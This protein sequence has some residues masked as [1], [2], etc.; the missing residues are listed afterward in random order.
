MVSIYGFKISSPKVN[1]VNKEKKNKE[2]KVTEKWTEYT[3]TGVADGLGTLYIYG[4]QN[5][6]PREKKNNKKSKSQKKREAEQAK[7]QEELEANPFLSSEDLE[8]KGENDV[9]EDSGLDDALLPLVRTISLDVERSEKTGA[10]RSRS[11]AYKEYNAERRPILKDFR[12]HYPQQAYNN[13]VNTL[14]RQ[15]G[16]TPV[17]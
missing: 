16:Y 8:D 6:I 9:S 17:N 1:S 2:G 4:E 12:N 10:K 11:E 13:A 15:Y 7:E 3:Y 5:L 14:N